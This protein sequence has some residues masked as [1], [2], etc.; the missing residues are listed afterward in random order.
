MLNT[1]ASGI[2]NNPIRVPSRSLTA[3]IILALEPSG[4]R[5]CARVWFAVATAALL[6]WLTCATVRPPSGPFVGVIKFPSGGAPGLAVGP[7]QK[8]ATLNVAG[9]VASE[10]SVVGFTNGSV[11]P[12]IV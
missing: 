2:L 7:P 3:I 9:A 11:I 8:K 12:F 10:G 1:V 5:I 4:S 6:I